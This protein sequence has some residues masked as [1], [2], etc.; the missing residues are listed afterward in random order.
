LRNGELKKLPKNALPYS[1]ESLAEVTTADVF[2]A[3]SDL[4]VDV[5]GIDPEELIAYSTCLSLDYSPAE[6]MG[7]SSTME[8]YVNPPEYRIL[9]RLVHDNLSDDEM[10]K[11]LSQL[12][13]FMLNQTPTGIMKSL[14]SY[15]TNNNTIGIFSIDFQKWA[16]N[17]DNTARKT[18]IQGSLNSG[19]IGNN[20]KPILEVQKVIPFEDE[21]PNITLV[22][23]D[24]TTFPG[25]A[26]LTVEEKSGLQNIWQVNVNGQDT[27]YKIFQK[28]SSVDVYFYPDVNGQTIIAIADF[29]DTKIGS[30]ISQQTNKTLVE[31]LMGENGKKKLCSDLK[32]DEW[33][34]IQKL[35]DKSLFTIISE[36]IKNPLFSDELLK[37]LMSP[38]FSVMN[39]L[40]EKYPILKKPYFDVLFN[41][42]PK[43]WQTDFAASYYGASKRKEAFDNSVDK[44]VSAVQKTVQEGFDKALIEAPNW[45]WDKIAGLWNKKMGGNFSDNVSGACR[46]VNTDSACDKDNLKEVY[47]ETVQ[48]NGSVKKECCSTGQPLVCDSR[49]RV[50]LEQGTCAFEKGEVLEKGALVGGQ[51][52]DACCFKGCQQCRMANA[53]EIV[54]KKCP[55]AAEELKETKDVNG[56]IIKLCCSKRTQR[57]SYENGIKMGEKCCVSVTDCITNQFADGLSI[58]AEMIAKNAIPVSSL[59]DLPL[60]R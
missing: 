58:L 6:I 44:A 24:K 16:I 57:D 31:L 27:K 23:I 30:L 35:F 43:E 26:D 13:D 33:A 55:T 12:L 2:K 60:S 8:H 25:L 49:C 53:R 40:A 34:M 47:R 32:C 45:L 46:E 52:V 48:P 29:L 17:T 59:R 15:L 5:V 4:D 18:E 19:R 11:A 50:K 14:G 37:K 54:N 41:K 56:E 42:L 21:N 39:Y 1:V 3:L 51:K 7:L 10:P 22:K 20:L 28:T 38:N 36:N 9:F